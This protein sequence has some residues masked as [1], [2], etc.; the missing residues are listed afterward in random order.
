MAHLL[1]CIFLFPLTDVAFPFLFLLSFFRWAGVGLNEDAPSSSVL[2]T[3][4]A[5][6]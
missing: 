4:E 3:Q 6:S 5:F 1:P 2:I